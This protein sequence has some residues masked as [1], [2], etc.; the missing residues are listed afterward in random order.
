MSENLQSDWH[1]YKDKKL[2][3]K[4]GDPIPEGLLKSLPFQLKK[5]RSERY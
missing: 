1:F 5:K 3:E 2:S 4:G